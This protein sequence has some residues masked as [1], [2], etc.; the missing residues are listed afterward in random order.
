MQM[1]GI[2]VIQLAFLTHSQARPNCLTF[3]QNQGDLPDFGMTKTKM[4][5]QPFALRPKPWQLNG[6]LAK[7]IISHPNLTP[8]ICK[9]WRTCLRRIQ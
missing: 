3:G 7:L 2:G 6:L 1:T 9:K 8:T 5:F 4:F